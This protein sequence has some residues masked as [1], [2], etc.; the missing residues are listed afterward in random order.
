MNEKTEVWKYQLMNYLQDNRQVLYGRVVNSDECADLIVAVLTTCPSLSGTIIAGDLTEYV[1]VPKTETTAC[2]S[3]V[4]TVGVTP[5]KRHDPVNNPAHYTQ[6]KVECIEA[7]EA[8]LSPQEYV[9][10]LRGQVM[11]Y[12]WRL[13]AKDE[14]VE[15]ASKASWYLQRLIAFL[16]RPAGVQ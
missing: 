15:N 12:N 5:G 8:A 1:S 2:V 4:L 9:G 11:K 3:D 7:I 16:K 14:P 13:T 10:F 6:G